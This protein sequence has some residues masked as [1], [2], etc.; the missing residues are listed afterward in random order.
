[1][2][3]MV[4]LMLRM[5]IN[6][7]IYLVNSNRVL[8]GHL[9]EGDMRNFINYDGKVAPHDKLELSEHIFKLE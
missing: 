8:L 4:I 3:E 9:L 1:M 7:N 2:M 5:I 6:L